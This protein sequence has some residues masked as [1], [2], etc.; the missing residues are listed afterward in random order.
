[1]YVDKYYSLYCRGP[2]NNN[3]SNHIG[4][5]F[6]YTNA[7]LLQ[8]ICGYHRIFIYTHHIRYVYINFHT[9]SQ[10]NTQRLRGFSKAVF[11]AQGLLIVI[12][13]KL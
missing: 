4:I 7:W 8:R 10:A 11:I 3:T 12:I 1:M 2:C 9:N 5:Y 6:G 13:R